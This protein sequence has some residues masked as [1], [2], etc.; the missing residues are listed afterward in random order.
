ML[1]T[2]WG[3]NGRGRLKLRASLLM[4]RLG[5]STI[6][7]YQHL[8]WKL[9]FIEIVSFLALCFVRPLLFTGTGRGC[10]FLHKRCTFLRRKRTWVVYVSVGVESVKGERESTSFDRRTRTGTVHL[11]WV[12]VSSVDGIWSMIILMWQNKTTARRQKLSDRFRPSPLL[13]LRKWS[14]FVVP[15]GRRLKTEGNG[16]T[17]HPWVCIA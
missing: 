17:V 15:L 8:G 9:Y 3:R 11:R 7:L 14:I 5:A 10:T 2:Q 6:I 1:S 4:L 13:G 16:D 12:V